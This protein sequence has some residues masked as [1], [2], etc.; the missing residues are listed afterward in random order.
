MNGNKQH[1]VSTF[2]MH[3]R[4]PCGSP[5]QGN[6]SGAGHMKTS[7]PK[8]D[9]DT[10]TD[11]GTVWAVF[12]FECVHEHAQIMWL[13]QRDRFMHD[14]SRKEKRECILWKRVRL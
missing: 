3:I 6:G 10:A 8:N 11:K 2:R 14:C 13:Y 12:G 7:G 1:Y 4:S 5:A 9:L